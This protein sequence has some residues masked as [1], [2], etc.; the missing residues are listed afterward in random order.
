M[1]TAPETYTE[2]VT[3]LDELT[4]RITTGKKHFARGETLMAE[5]ITLYG[6]LNNA[7]PG[8]YLDLIQF[9][10][11]QAIALPNDDQWQ[12]MKGQRNKIVAEYQAELTSMQAKKA[13]A[14]A[15]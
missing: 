13:A 11:A 14:D 4:D 9:I 10:D 15:A 12:H 5:G 1:T 7:A 3:A 8:G 2:A 6:D